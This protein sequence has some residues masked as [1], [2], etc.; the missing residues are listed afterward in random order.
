M[1][2][3]LASSWNVPTGHSFAHIFLS[4][5][6]KLQMSV[7]LIQLNDSIFKY[8]EQMLKVEISHKFSL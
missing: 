2:Y 6:F 1:Q 4:G 3:A 8:S 5:Y 7:S